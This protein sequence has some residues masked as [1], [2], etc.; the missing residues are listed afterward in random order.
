MLP[1][2]HLNFSSIF[3]LKWKVKWFI[4]I[5]A[6][7][8]SSNSLVGCTCIC[9]WRE[10]TCFCVYYLFDVVHITILFCISHSKLRRLNLKLLKL[11]GKQYNLVI[12]RI[13][14]IFFAHI[15]SLNSVHIYFIVKNKYN[16]T[17]NKIK[18]LVVYPLYKDIIHS[19]NSQ[20]PLTA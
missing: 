5:N 4:F 20:M 19:K 6:T 15:F 7:H 9:A 18:R 1:L 13:S 8:F 3:P 11:E 16:L 17:T 2:I 14:S 10:V 12:K